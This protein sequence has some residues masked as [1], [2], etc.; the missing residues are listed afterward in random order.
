MS[1][2][3]RS[4]SI[5]RRLLAPI[6]A[7]CAAL[8]VLG[9]CGEPSDE[10][11]FKA[12]RENLMDV[13]AE[14]EQAQA[15]VDDKRELVEAAQSELDAALEKLQEAKARLEEARGK[16]DVSATDAILFREVQSA[17]LADER[18]E[19][20]AVAASVRGGVV[21]LTG[22]VR[23]AE[24]RN[25]AVEIAQNTTGVSRVESRI[26]VA[27]SDSGSD[28]GSKQDTAAEESPPPHPPSD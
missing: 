24:Q 25:R 6:G 3:P 12:A 23:K 10:A 7:A 28:S 16:V 22:E 8:L 19:S 26:Q 2:P 15:V 4:L 21:T 5:P 13:R 11:R 14:V 9:A 18:L 27:A 1:R 17:L 20:V